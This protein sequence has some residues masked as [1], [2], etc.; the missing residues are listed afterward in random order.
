MPRTALNRALLTSLTALLLAA[1]GGGDSGGSGTAPPASCDLAEQKT[2]LARTMDDQ[3]FWYRLAPRPDPAPYSSITAYFDAL[4]YTGGTPP[5]PADRWSRSETDASFNRFFGDGATLGYGV[6]VAGLEAVDDPRRPLLVRLVDPGSP[7]AGRVQRGARIVSLNGRPA[8]EIVAADD[9]SALT[10]NASGDVLNLVIERNGQNQPLSLTA[11]VYNLVPVSDDQVLTLADGRRVGVVQV[12][13]MVSQA[14]APLETVFSNFRARGVSELVLD[15][16][17]NGGGLVSVGAQLASY[18]AS[19]AVAGQ[20]YASL[21]YND[22]RQSSNSRQNFAN[23]GN[24]LNLR[25]VYVLMGRRTCSAAEQVI[26]GLRGVGVDVVGIGEASCGKP[27]GSNPVSA[28]GRT[29]SVINFESVNAR[30]E[31]RYFD[32]LE[33]TCLVD[34]DF[35]QLQGG[36]GDPLLSG[37]LTFAQSGGCPRRPLADGDERAQAQSLVRPLRRSVRESGHD[38][39][40]SEREGGMLPR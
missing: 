13:Q 22:K 23:L 17:Y 7:A 31:G 36:A 9:F 8:A 16:R 38:G 6:A 5:F 10:A 18:V 34:E 2:W 25:R 11:A 14:N 12:R 1:C 32:G 19:P 27:V 21:L 33:P 39:P 4:L 29:Y 3:Y 37:A 20:A 26:N 30:N 35:S 24:G 40:G 15:L 28:C